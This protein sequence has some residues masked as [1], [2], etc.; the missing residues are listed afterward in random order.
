MCAIV[1]MFGRM[2]SSG[3]SILLMLCFNPT[4]RAEESR[5]LWS[6]KGSPIMVSRRAAGDRICLFNI[7]H[8]F[9]SSCLT[10][11]V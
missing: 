9:V 11:A 3:M 6:Q 8:Y 4:P 10:C 7:Y 2:R 5:R 1:G